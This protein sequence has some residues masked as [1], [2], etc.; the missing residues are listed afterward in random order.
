MQDLTSDNSV[1]STLAKM[2]YTY[3]PSTSLYKVKNFSGFHKK[4]TGD[5]LC[6]YDTINAVKKRKKGD[7]VIVLLGTSMRGKPV[8]MHSILLD[9][10]GDVVEDNNIGTKLEGDYVRGQGYFLKGTHTMLYRDLVFL[11]VK[12]FLEMTHLSSNLETA[13]VSPEVLDDTLKALYVI[14]AYAFAPYDEQ[15]EE[16]IRPIPKAVADASKKWEPNLEKFAAQFKLPRT[17]IKKLLNAARLDKS[18]DAETDKAVTNLG[19]AIFRARPLFDK[20]ITIPAEKLTLIKDLGTA[21]RSSSPSA[22]ARLEKKVVLLKDPTLSSIFSIAELA[23]ISGGD[24]KAVF[25]QIKKLTKKYARISTDKLSM[26]DAARLRDSNPEAYK[27]YTKLRTEAKKIY[28]NFVRDFVRKSGRPYVNVE[29][30]R[31]ALVKNKIIHNLPTGFVGNV[32]ESLNLVTT[33][34]RTIQGTAALSVEMNPKY[35]PKEDNSYVFKVKTDKGINNIYTLDY[36]ASKRGKKKEEKLSDLQSNYTKYRNKWLQDLKGADNRKK[37]MAAAVELIFLTGARTGNPGNATI[38]RATGE[39]IP[40]YGITTLKAKHVVPYKGG[41]RISYDGKKL[42][43]N[44][45]V[46][47]PKTPTNKK[48]I[49]VIGE[50]KDGK[51]P[52][53]PLWTYKEKQIPTLAISNYF[54]SLGSKSTLHSVRHMLGTKLAKEVLAESPLKKGKVSQAAAEKWFKEALIKVGEAL[55]HTTGAKPTAI[56][57]I[58]SYIDPNL[59]VDFF[60]KLGLRTPKWL[61]IKGRI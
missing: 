29:D 25:D 32:D 52:D 21:F 10:E 41:Y 23:P 50:L 53:E 4:F 11:P 37:Y 31:K 46:V 8:V 6:H 22:V 49:S 45:Y 24:Q 3:N 36:I 13:K 20:D 12:K 7:D 14:F 28:E 2:A 40:T 54:K 61:Q 55:G 38:D 1:E 47:L 34:G 17:A 5:N 9:S 60:N 48:L 33:A 57:A 27:Q 19:I 35:D 59:Q 26:E 58:K 42:S 18:F 15:T 39:K 56:T 51:K 16:S 43:T 30:I 44:D